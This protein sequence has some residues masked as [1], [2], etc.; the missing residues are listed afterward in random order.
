[1][2]AKEAKMPADSPY[3][4]LFEEVKIGPIVAPNRFYQV[5]HATG[6]G[7]LYSNAHAAFRETRAEGG[8]GV[9]STGACDIHYSSDHGHRAFDRIWDESDVT[10]HAKLTEG[11]H[12]HGSLAAIE[13]NHSA[14]ASLSYYATR[15]VP[16]GVSSD[17]G[18]EID[19]PVQSRV[20]DKEDI[21]NLRRWHRDA[22]LR[23][24]RAG[25][26]IVYVYAAHGNQV[27]RNFFM[28]E[29]NHR[30][31]E[32]G[33][34]LE[35][36]ARLLKELLTD[37]KEAVG[38]KC[39]VALRF[40]VEDYD[41]VTD[42]GLYRRE[43][44]EVVEYL[45]DIPDLWD[46]NLSWPSDAPS[47]RFGEEGFQR[48]L[49]SFVKQIT[50][51]PVVGVGRF[52]SPDTMVDMI[53]KG[54]IDLIGAARPSIADPFLPKKIKE[55]RLEEIRECIGCNV[56][57]SMS[58]VAAPI[59]CT[60]NPTT[61]E[62]WRRNWHPE[63]I[64]PKKSDSRVLVV[65]SG[66]AGLEC[67]TA[68][69]RRGYEV[70]LAEKGRELGGRVTLESKLP[71]LSAWGRVRDHRLQLL[72]KLPNVEIFRESD[73]TAG[74]VL[75]L[76]YDHIVLATGATWRRDGIG[77]SSRSAI[78]GIETAKVFTP[79]DV[80]KGADLPSPVLIYDDDHNYMASVMAEKLV[81]QG[82]KVAFVTPGNTAVSWS[83]HTLDQRNIIDRMLSIGVMIEIGMRLD[84]VDGTQAIFK[85]NLDY[86]ETTVEF[87]SILVVTNRSSTEKL[88]YA[89]NERRP[90]FL[91]RG[92]KSLTRIGDCLAPGLIATA[93]FSGH[94]WARNLDEAPTN[95]LPFLREY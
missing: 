77:G 93:V 20:M 45:K 7:R 37:T 55:G 32:Y 94:E 1:M 67:A 29:F 73:L 6:L 46:V 83:R 42:S 51:K 30:A 36:R 16:F 65:G 27:A 24:K 15:T 71:G 23:A 87:A 88:F 61:S 90:E 63:R 26:D 80:M 79:D 50:S 53:K 39:A 58:V 18:Y 62:E 33:G 82:K 14:A 35:N 8:W 59:Q 21:R 2:P 11:A 25:Y 22:A 72:E 60:Q 69:G 28:P 68:L 9:V 5:P 47:S 84:N 75:D 85:R 54:V 92:V 89:L 64:P 81:Q 12:R 44:R 19:R 52:T 95:D 70:A 13:L 74:D 76:G 34:S 57:I 66:P 17:K 31:D 3:S 56:C 41:V 4:I 48:D 10:A 91:D 43:A 38:D 86:K 78:P 49:V 40:S